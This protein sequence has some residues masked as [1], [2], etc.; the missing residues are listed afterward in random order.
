M[1]ATNKSRMMQPAYSCVA[2]SPTPKQFW[3]PS[4]VLKCCDTLVADFGNVSL[5]TNLYG[6]K[7]ARFQS[8]PSSLVKVC[9]FIPICLSSSLPPSLS[10]SPPS[11]SLSLPLRFLSTL[12]K[13]N[14]VNSC[15][16][17]HWFVLPF[18][19]AGP[20]VPSRQEPRKPRGRGNCT[21]TVVNFDIVYSWLCIASESFP[22]PHLIPLL[23]DLSPSFPFLPFSLSSSLIISP[24]TLPL[25]FPPSSL[26]HSSSPPSLSLSLSP[27]SSRSS[28]TPSLSWVMK[29]SGRFMTSMA[30]WDSN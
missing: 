23:L 24:L 25:L 6:T 1:D 7:P 17:S 12:P 15:G 19:V 2:M 30:P 3:I 28:T 20:E 21:L 4:M 10:P 13:Y 22:I 27:S 5:D 14:Y 26:H 9:S 18:L 11:P 16:M 8:F 29:E